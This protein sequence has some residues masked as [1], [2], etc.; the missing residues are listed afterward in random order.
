MAQALAFRHSAES[1]PGARPPLLPLAGAWRIF[2]LKDRTPRL[3]LIIE[4]ADPAPRRGGVRA[5]RG[6]A[7]EEAELPFSES[8]V[9]RHAT[10]LPVEGVTNDHTVA[11]QIF[12]VLHG[13][14]V[15]EFSLMTGV[16]AYAGAPCAAERPPDGLCAH[17]AHS[18]RVEERG[19]LHCTLCGLCTPVCYE[20]EEFRTFEGQK[21]RNH[22]GGG[23]GH[24]LLA[25]H[26]LNTEISDRRQPAGARSR[27]LFRPLPRSA[28]GPRERSP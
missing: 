11:V 18:E 2:D 9:L 7:W 13:T 20:G 22:H 19:G 5:W 25:V 16:G 1:P 24:P 28:A 12:T 10:A 8:P 23:G 26:G 17:C 3:R 14:C 15:L 21:D 6:R 27:A 4:S